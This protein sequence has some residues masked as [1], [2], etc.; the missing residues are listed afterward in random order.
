MGAGTST[1]GRIT[2]QSIDSV[3]D[4]ADLVDIAGAHTQLHKR[5]AEHSGRCP[6]HD[7]RTPSFW[8]NSAKGV[9]HCFGCGASGDVI[10]FLQQKQGLDFVEAVEYLADRYRV[11]LEYEQGGQRQKQHQSRRRLFELLDAATAFFEHALWNAASAQI[12]RDYLAERGVTQDTAR[13]FRLGYSPDGDVLTRKAM[14]RG[15][16]KQ[17]LDATGL[18]SSTGREAFHGRLMFPI[19]DRAGR[20]HGFGARQLR[21][22]DPIKG[23][24]I[25]S[26]R[27]TFFDKSRLLYAA[28][29]LVNAA[30]KDGAV[31]VVEG[32]LDVIALWQ[33]GFRNVCASMGTSV[34][35][36]QV[37][38]LKR[39]APR[40]IF[41]LDGD[42]AGQGAIVRAL[43]K[44]QSKELDVRIAVMP[45]DQ[46]PD[47][48][49][50]APG[51]VEQ[52]RG[53]L[54]QA[55]P[56]LAFRTSVLLASGDLS[57]AAERDR[58][59]REAIELLRFSPDGPLKREQVKRVE[60]VLRFDTAEAEEFQELV[61]A[62]RPLRMTR[63]DSWEPKR[64]GEREV[65][66]RVAS[67]G[68]H[69]TTITR[70]KRLLAVALQLA[71]RDSAAALAGLLP[72]EE[73]F[74]LTVH[75]RARTVLV[76][77]GAPALA[78]ARVRDDEELFA[79][80]AQLSTLA[81]RDRV[82][83][84]DVETLRETVTELSRA[85]Q[86]QDVERRLG[87][88]RAR[89][90]DGVPS[91]EDAAELVELRSRQREL[92]PRARGRDS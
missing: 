16:S 85:V 26:R 78:P 48:V 38:E 80:V 57:D 61:G 81:E 62:A 36:E 60:N 56:L 5:G 49:V 18:L 2:Q 34:T 53:L 54:D 73:A 21:D 19:I 90:S 77:G 87:E 6:F 35:D 4:R 92:D 50:K 75:R 24:Y 33:A 9:Y 59:Y 83:A 41:A 13:A 11:E 69:S 70:E 10:T 23:K 88:L 37:V 51:G 58:I 42:P 39:H 65:A 29:G 91:D 1:S 86:L 3:L 14:E 74:T 20:T 15:F 22:D 32:Y 84:E 45:E 43:E 67:S 27:S 25:N 89:L 79:L 82:G 66:R 17:E 30:R 46:D 71:D 55:V 12:A 44:A 63:Q 64:R 31:V 7:E 28:P 8:V 40:A 52:V 47:D 68:Q 76:D 72:P